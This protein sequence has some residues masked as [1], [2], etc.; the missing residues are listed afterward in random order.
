MDGQLASLS[1]SWLADTAL[2]TWIW[3]VILVERTRG[4]TVSFIEVSAVLIVEQGR[5]R[6]LRRDK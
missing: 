5:G 2:G 4:L 3:E 1:P 6:L